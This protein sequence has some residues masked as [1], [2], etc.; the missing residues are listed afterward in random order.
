MHVCM[1]RSLRDGSNNTRAGNIHAGD[2]IAQGGHTWSR[3]GIRWAPLQ[4]NAFNTSIQV[5]GD[6]AEDRLK[7]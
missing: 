1:Q 6:E 2:P 7:M 4:L 5:L 3:D